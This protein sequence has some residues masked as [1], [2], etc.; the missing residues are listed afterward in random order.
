LNKWAVELLD[1]EVIAKQ[2][3]LNAQTVSRLWDDL[4]KNNVW[5]VQIWYILM[6]QS[7]LRQNGY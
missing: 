1:P 2:G 7:W 6:F 4:I 5:K 3:F